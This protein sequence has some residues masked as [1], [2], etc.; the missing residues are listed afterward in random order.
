MRLL[1]FSLVS[2]KIS[3]SP[4]HWI[5]DAAVLK[6]IP[7]A[8]AVFRISGVYRQSDSPRYSE[9]RA[10]HFFRPSQRVY[11]SRVFSCSSVKRSSAATTSAADSSRACRKKRTVVANSC[12][13]RERGIV[14]RLLSCVQNNTNSVQS[15][16]LFVQ[17]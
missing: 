11:E 17:F 12:R 3:H 6:D 15:I 1:L 13:I 9:R 5:A 2:T 16:P 7:N 8:S 10:R 4:S 14:H